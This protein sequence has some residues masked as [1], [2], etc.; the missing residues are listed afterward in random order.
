MQLGEGDGEP[1][2]AAEYERTEDCQEGDVSSGEEATGV[3]LEVQ[4]ADVK[5]MNHDGEEDV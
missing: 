3:G 5:S 1:S 4:D 2:E